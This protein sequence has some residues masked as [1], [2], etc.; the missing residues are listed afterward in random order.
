MELEILQALYSIHN[1]ILDAIMTF[2]THLGDAGIFWIAI[3]IVLIFTKKYRKAGIVALVSLIL[4]L[5]FTNG[6]LKHLFNRPRPFTFD[7]TVKLL[8]STPH[9]SS[10]PSGHSSASMA[11]AVS[12]FI[13]DKKIGIP[14]IVVALLIAFSRLYI[15]VHY[16]TDVLA[17]LF[18]GTVY[19]IT[20]ALIVNTIYKKKGLN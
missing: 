15:F 8:I 16:P 6:I 17:G 4:S 12:F 14:A 7:E 11:A 5:R 10:F 1:P 18:V 20:A 19:A 9:D 13:Y 2:I 3:A